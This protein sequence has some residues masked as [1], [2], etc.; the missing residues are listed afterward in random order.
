[1]S[2]KKKRVKVKVSGV[3]LVEKSFVVDDVRKALDKFEK[4]YGASDVITGEYKIG[5]VKYRILQFRDFG[6]GNKKIEISE[7][8]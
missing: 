3:R 6:V 8:K 2:R 7:S 5:K 1:M 4:I